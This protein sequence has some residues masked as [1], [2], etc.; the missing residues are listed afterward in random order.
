MFF[1][2]IILRSFLVFLSYKKENLKGSAPIFD[3]EPWTN[4]RKKILV[5]G[6]VNICYSQKLVTIK[7]A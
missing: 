3:K 5:S 6:L 7:F 1:L 4:N 2:K